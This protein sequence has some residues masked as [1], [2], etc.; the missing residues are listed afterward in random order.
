MYEVM[1]GFI[2]IAGGGY[3]WLAAIGKIQISK[4]EEKSVEWRAKYGNLVKILAPIVI[5][6]GLFRLSQPLLGIS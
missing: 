1:D 6:F 5:A 3:A 2:S 4:T